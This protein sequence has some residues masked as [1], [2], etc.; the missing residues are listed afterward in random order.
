MGARWLWYAVCP[1]GHE[2]D[3]FSGGADP[4][5]ECGEEPA[6]VVDCP[7]WATEEPCNCRQ[8]AKEA[9]SSTQSD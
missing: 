6:V 2:Y 4:C 9:F 5:Y 3:N 8:V 1:N 7:H